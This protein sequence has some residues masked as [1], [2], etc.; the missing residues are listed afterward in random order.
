VPY[1]LEI[2]YRGEWFDGV[3]YDVNG[4]PILVDYKNGFESWISDD[5]TEFVEWVTR[6][7]VEDKIAAEASRQTE[8]ANG[9]PVEWR[10]SSQKF[11]DFLKDW[12]ERRG[13][14]GIRA[15]HTPKS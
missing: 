2:K 14:T 5:G 1:G 11:A 13:I 15:V 6:L 9:L 7:G 3:I 8:A 12:F 10:C 4:A